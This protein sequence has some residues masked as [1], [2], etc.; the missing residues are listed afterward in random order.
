MASVTARKNKAGKIISYQIKVTRG[1]DKVT[2]KQLTP[3]TMTYTPPEGWSKKAIDRDLKKVMGEFETA[4]TRGEVLTKE[5]QKAHALEKA[6]QVEREQAEEDKKPTFN[7]YMEIFIKEKAATLSAMTIQAYKQSLKRPAAVFGEMKLEDIDF[8]MVK[9]FI[10]D[11]QGTQ[12]SKRKKPL[13]H[14]T[15]VT[16][17]T[18][19]HTLFES[20][21]ENGVIQSN[22]LQRMKKPKPRKDDIPAEPIVY[23][24]TEVAYIM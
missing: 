23:S 22:P 8:L 3:Y 1:R 11:L 24:E 5:E 21:V 10:T 7:K 9:Q 12:K 2:G 18:T 19:L 15:I 17:Y 6:A 14:G 13:A 20:A 16:Y 4:C